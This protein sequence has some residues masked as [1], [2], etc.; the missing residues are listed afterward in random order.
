MRRALVPLMSA[1]AVLFAVPSVA[2]AT[3][4]GRNGRIAFSDGSRIWTVRPDGSGGR[5]VFRAPRGLRVSGGPVF[6]PSGHTIAFNTSDAN[7]RGC[8][9]W[10]MADSGA[11]A[12]RLGPLQLCDVSSFSPSGR[13]LYARGRDGWSVLVSSRSGHIGR[14]ISRSLWPLVQSLRGALAA[15]GCFTLV[16]NSGGRGTRTLYRYDGT[17]DY[18]DTCAVGP[19]LDWSPGGSRLATVLTTT[20]FEYPSG[21]FADATFCYASEVDVFSPATGGQRRLVQDAW[22]VAWSPDDASIAYTTGRGLYVKPVR[23]GRARLVTRRATHSTIISW[24]ARPPYRVLR[25]ACLAY[26]G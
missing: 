24:Q 20:G 3:F 25:P 16:V 23:G 18:G 1:L 9:L 2:S 7:G 15:S 14:R 19:G 11:R 26:C 8:R 22:G 4:P 13:W 17:V 6:S 12:R 21:C 5:V 10:V